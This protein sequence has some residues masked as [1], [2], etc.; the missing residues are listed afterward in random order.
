MAL[1]SGASAGNEKI[2]HGSFRAGSRAEIGHSR[3]VPSG[4]YL[5]GRTASAS[6]TTTTVGASRAATALRSVSLYETEG[7]HFLK[8]SARSEPAAQALHRKYRDTRADPIPEASEVTQ[9]DHEED[10]RGH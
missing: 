8:P 4:V 2:W 10:Q 9:H 7:D 6:P 3:P 1:R 5:D